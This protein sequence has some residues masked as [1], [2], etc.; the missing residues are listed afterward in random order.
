MR[1]PDFSNLDAVG[2][3]LQ[4]IFDLAGLPSE[5]LAALRKTHEVSRFRQL[6]LI[7]HGGRQ[8]WES[9]TASGI[10]GADPVDSFTR[11]AL[12]RWFSAHHPDATYAFAY[13]GD[14]TVDLQRLGTL[15][16]WHHPSPFGVGIN[17]QW[18]SWFA[19]RAAVLADTALPATPTTQGIS[20]CTTCS[21]HP[22]IAACP[23]DALTGGRISLVK[24]LAYRGQPDSHCRDTC[25]A[26]E[27]C[28]VA[29][30]HRYVEEQLK[31]CYGRSLES[32]L[33]K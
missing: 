27:S 24:C 10:A 28:P 18:G 22:C 20:P 21:E 33:G 17:A 32:I 5:L 9:I 12:T 14:I 29:P 16:G 11:D 2:L 3:N 6:I 30:Q 4:A 31:H 25:V 13:P 1:V 23:A 19:Y 7:G 26:R 8:L 15:A